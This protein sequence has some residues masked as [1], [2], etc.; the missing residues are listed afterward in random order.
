MNSHTESTFTESFECSISVQSE[1][2]MRPLLGDL[3][4]QLAEQR[5][6]PREPAARELPA[7]TPHNAYT[8]TQSAIRS[9]T[10]NMVQTNERT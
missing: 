4:N 9:E 10:T 1:N 5:V 7:H 2:E 3:D 8:Q 6:G